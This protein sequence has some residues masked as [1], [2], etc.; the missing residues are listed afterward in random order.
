VVMLMGPMY[1]LTERADRMT[2]L[3]EAR[4]C[5][6][7]GS[8]LFVA[9]ISRYASLLDGFRA[10]HIEDPAFLP[11]LDRDLREGQHRNSTDNFGY[12]TTAF[13]HHPDELQSE[14]KEAEFEDV[15]VLAVEGPAWLSP[16]LEGYMND[17]VMRER[18]L[19]LVRRVE[20]DATMLALSAHLLAIG[21]R[22]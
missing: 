20:C 22:P 18:T 13:F 19:E 4:R 9:A 5:L 3:T 16:R 8:V 7:P 17:A 15:E 10:G 14:L 2:A 21:R 6:R 11:I 12:F 1:H